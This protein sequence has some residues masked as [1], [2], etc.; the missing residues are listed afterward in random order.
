M[1]AEFQ[2]VIIYWKNHFVCMF[3]IGD[4]ELLCSNSTS[5]LSNNAVWVIMIYITS[6]PTL[7]PCAIYLWKCS[8]WI[9]LMKISQISK[10]N[11]R[12]KVRF[13][14]RLDAWNLVRRSR[15]EMFCK[16]NSFEKIPNF[17]TRAWDHWRSS[18]SLASN[19]MP[20]SAN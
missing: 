14:L 9:T 16:I 7:C 2:H 20:V 17:H 11:I 6:E 18:P 3:A 15:S 13:L 10:E 1:P 8:S 4:I 5:T 12:D 19:V